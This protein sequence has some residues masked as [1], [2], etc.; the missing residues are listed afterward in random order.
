[1]TSVVVLVTSAV[2]LGLAGPGLDGAGGCGA[3][4][5]TTHDMAARDSSDQIKLVREFMS[6]SSIPS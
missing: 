6:Y 4:P 2:V 5:Q 1:M 3:Q